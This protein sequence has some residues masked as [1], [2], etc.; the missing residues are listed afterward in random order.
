MLV[1]CFFALTVANGQKVC[2]VFQF[3]VEGEQSRKLVLTKEYSAENR[4]IKETAK[5]YQV[6]LDN[7]N[8]MYSQKEDGLYEYYYD[9]TVL[10]KTVYTVLDD[11]TGAPID[12][13]KVFRYFDS[14]NRLIREV[15]VNHLNVRKQGVKPGLFRNTINYYYDSLGRLI[16]KEG[17]YGNNTRSFLNYDEKGRLLSDSATNGEA[18]GL[19]CIV[20]KYEY[21]YDGYR[22][23]AW[24]C[25]RKYPIITVFRYDNN[26]RV[27]EQ[28]V[29]FH[30]NDEKSGGRKSSASMNWGAYLNNDFANYRQVERTIFKYNQ[31][32]EIVETGYYHKGRHTTTHVFEYE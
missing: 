30:K 24:M 6:F 9:D 31:K 32:G 2:K 25:D 17:V 23:Y 22:E 15:N 29:W 8:T 13:G 28:A 10:Y 1:A 27:T 21:R 26:N 7:S 20:T 3:G 12:S 5:G 19:F 14:N 4:L 18:K 11:L 16:S